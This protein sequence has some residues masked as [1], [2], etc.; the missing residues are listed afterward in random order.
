MVSF[1][2]DDFALA[3]S[4]SSDMLELCRQGKVDA[5]S[6]IPNISCFDECMQLYAAACPSFPRAV[7]LS[8]HLNVMEGR[9]V[10]SPE[11]LRDL[12]DAQGLFKVSWLSLLRDSFLPWKRGRIRRELAAEGLPLAGVDCIPTAKNGPFREFLSALDLSHDA[13][14]WYGDGK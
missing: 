13:V 6:V 5:I 1:H 9:P 10:S 11:S 8:V 14:T 12:V 7:T 2:A 4:S 3:V